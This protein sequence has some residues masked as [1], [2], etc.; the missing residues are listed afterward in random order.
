MI[1]DNFWAH[2][3]KLVSE[4]F[5]I[6]PDEKQQRTWRTMLD[7]SGVTDEQFGKAVK[8][9]VANIK[10]WFPNH[11]LV[12]LVQEYITDVYRPQAQAAALNA[13][14][15]PWPKQLRAATSDGNALLA[16]HKAAHEHFKQQADGADPRRAGETVNDY[17]LR[18]RAKFLTRCRMDGIAIPRPYAE[19]WV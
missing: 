7:D 17:E 11:N 5:K 10:Q 9:I 15:Q 6:S 14:N 2:G 18:I 4:T 16:F 13:Q 12:A 1:T 19:A 8:F 3:M